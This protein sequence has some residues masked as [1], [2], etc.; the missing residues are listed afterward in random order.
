[1]F[2]KIVDAINRMEDRCEI[3]TRNNIRCKNMRNVEVGRGHMCTKHYLSSKGPID[4]AKR[5]CL[6][7]FNRARVQIHADIIDLNQLQQELMRVRRRYLRDLDDINNDPQLGW[8]DARFQRIRRYENELKVRTTR[9]VVERYR[10]AKEWVD[11][12]DV[13][14]GNRRPAAE[15]EPEPRGELQVL[16]LD[17]QNVH[18]RI[19]VDE[20]FK[21]TDLIRKAAYVPEG[22]RW[23][24]HIFSATPYAVAVACQLHPTVSV[25]LLAMYSADVAIYEIEEGIYGKVL[26]SVWQYIKNSPHKNDLCKILGDEIIDSVGMCAQGNLSR[27]CNVL[28]GYLDGIEIKESTAET[29]GRMFPPLMDITEKSERLEK[30]KK[31]LMEYEVPQEEWAA[32]IEPLE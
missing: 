11:A 17:R 9:N 5:V 24:T 26:D 29:L 10:R 7:A 1:M 20:T 27:I 4:D 22:Y 6:M 12:E 23:S 2:H 25:H 14:I 3:W 21:I 16:A 31:I 19:V 13:E 18:T 30:A 32:W 8:D 15:P 28:S